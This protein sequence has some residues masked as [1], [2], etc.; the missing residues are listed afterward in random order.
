MIESLLLIEARRWTIRI[1]ASPPAR[2]CEATS[3]I[4]LSKK[5][6]RTLCNKNALDDYLMNLADDIENYLQEAGFFRVGC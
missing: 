2:V 6:S 4:T 3:T 5:R 1:I